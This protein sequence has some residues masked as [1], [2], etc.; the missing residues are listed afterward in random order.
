MRATFL[1]TLIMFFTASSAFAQVGPKQGSPAKPDTAKATV[2]PEAAKPQAQEAP[3]T[4]T[5]EMEPA[6]TQESAPEMT[7]HVKRALFTTAVEAR[8]PAGSIDSL[9]TASDEVYFFSE[10]VGLEGHTVT[11]RWLHNGEVLAEVL[12]TI[13]GPRWRVYS[14]K[15]LLPSWTGA[16]QVDVVNDDGSVL[17]SKQL[18]YYKAESTQ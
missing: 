7:G 5:E 10:I 17:A 18:E 3:K 14:S 11:H 1:L 12:F 2:A 15:K 8:E 4:S 13:G 16:L 6:Q 9:S